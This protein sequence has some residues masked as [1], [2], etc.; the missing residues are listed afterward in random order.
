MHNDKVLQPPLLSRLTNGIRRAALFV[1]RLAAF[2]IGTLPL[3]GIAL[4]LLAYWAYSN[5]APAPPPKPDAT[6]TRIVDQGVLRIGVDPSFPPFESDDGKGNLSGLDVALAG[7]IVSDWSNTVTNTIHVQYVYT[8]FDGL[9]D[10]L[11]A[12]QFDVILS[13]LPYDPTKTEDVSFSHSYYNGGPLIVVPDGNTSTHSWYDL[14]NRRVGVELGSSGDVFARK[15]QRR[16]K[17]DLSEFNTPEDALGALKAG[18]ISAVFTDFITFNDYAKTHSGL[19]TVGTPLS[20]ELYVIAVRKGAP[21]LLNEI[22][23]VIDAM[24][25]D[26]RMDRLEKVWF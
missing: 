1:R 12:N 7:A 26:G 5:L 14:A 13:A 20:D 4:V 25:R 10:A 22:N 9:Y 19:K 2:R 16:L 23:A 24:K 11:K 8:G 18:A 3:V 21:T 6:W 17:Y 15:W